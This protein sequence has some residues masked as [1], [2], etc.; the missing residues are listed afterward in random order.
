MSRSHLIL[1]IVAGALAATL[2]WTALTLGR[3]VYEDWAFLHQVR[4][5][6]EEQRLQQLRQAQQPQPPKPG[7]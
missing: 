1:S 6:T 3:V 5:Q 2:T 7:P 4:I